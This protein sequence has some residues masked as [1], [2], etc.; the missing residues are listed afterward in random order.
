MQSMTAEKKQV[1]D[2]RTKMENLSVDGALTPDEQ[3]KLDGLKA[4]RN[5]LKVQLE[6]KRD[7][8]KAKRDALVEEEMQEHLDDVIRMEGI[9]A[10]IRTLPTAPA[11]APAA[12]MAPASATGI[13]A[14]LS[15]GLGKAME[16]L[17]KMGE[18][19]K[20]M[21]DNLS[22]SG[23]RGLLKIGEMFPQLAFLADWARPA[24]EVA[25][26]HEFMEKDTAF[27]RNVLKADTDIASNK[28]LR[29]AYKAAITGGTKTAENF[30]FEQF[31]QLRI[32]ELKNTKLVGVTMADL[33]GTKSPEEITDANNK[34]DTQLKKLKENGFVQDA[35]D[36]E[37]WKLD[38]QALGDTAAGIPINAVFFKKNA[39]GAWEWKTNAEADF[40]TLRRLD[41]A[42]ASISVP[43]KELRAKMNALAGVLGIPAVAVPAPAP[44]A[45]PGGPSE[46]PEQKN[47]RH[48]IALAEALNEV[49]GSNAI[50][51]DKKNDW[52]IIA[53]EVAHKLESD[54]F[55][56]ALALQ[57]D[58]GVLEAT[59]TSQGS[60][61]LT[62]YFA[63]ANVLENWKEAVLTNPVVA[64]E[65]FLGIDPY[66][67]K[68]GY[69]WNNPALEGKSRGAIL[70]IQQALKAKLA[71]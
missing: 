28:T 45:P 60:S 41:E 1:T 33:A 51:I 71:L 40:T 68:E 31:I 47:S 57:I 49:A 66:K 34:N 8:A 2:L 43:V 23:K 4:E 6:A 10:S 39:A 13:S 5:A 58:D 56:T 15:N 20:K 38:G 7:T 52:K 24:V 69:L 11:R 32:V 64:V 42:Q 17:G 25:D 62:G 12:A 61:W 36:P 26:I 53:S 16:G 65:K 37:L 59:D 63:D 19:M 55:K 14:A 54:A 29:D 9:E 46:T 22:V 30:T 48:I 35:K 27:G 21:W 50:D 44:G 18:A 70:K 3:A 67:K